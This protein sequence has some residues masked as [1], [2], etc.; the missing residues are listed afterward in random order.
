MQIGFHKVKIFMFQKSV[1]SFMKS[2][3]K[4]VDKVP[5]K[6]E[7]ENVQQIK[8][9]IRELFIYGKAMVPYV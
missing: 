1:V 5:W 4:K 2:S 3:Q 8:Y 6:T 9:C 7:R